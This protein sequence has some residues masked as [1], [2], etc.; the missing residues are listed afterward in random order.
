M[1]CHET[2]LRFLTNRWM[3]NCGSTSTSTCT[4]SG[5]ISKAMISARYF[6]RSVSSPVHS[7]LQSDQPARR[8]DT[9]ASTRNDICWNAPHYCL[10][11]YP[12]NTSEIGFCFPKYA[13][14]P[15]QPYKGGGFTAPFQ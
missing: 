13:L 9:W 3:P 1:L 7:V 11:W 5:M 2:P 12:S 10:I 15:Q 8:S 4:W 6:Q 14:Y